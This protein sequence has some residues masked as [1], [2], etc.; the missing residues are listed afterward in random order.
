VEAEH[1]HNVP[2][3]IGEPNEHRHDCYFNVERPYYL[4]RV[5]RSVPGID[6]TLARYGEIWE[7]LAEL[8]GSG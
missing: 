4:E 5:D 7:R 1:L 8:R 2:S 3:L 6:F